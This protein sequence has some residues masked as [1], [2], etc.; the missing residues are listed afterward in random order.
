MELTQ[1]KRQ[2]QARRIIRMGE[3]SML[4]DRIMYFCCIF[5]YVSLYL[6]CDTLN[7]LQ[8]NIHEICFYINNYMFLFIQCIDYFNHKVL[9]L[10]YFGVMEEKVTECFVMER[11]TES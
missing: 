10:H 4:L 1:E 7:L 2:N 9:R 8:I 5:I 11:L 6:L 3:T